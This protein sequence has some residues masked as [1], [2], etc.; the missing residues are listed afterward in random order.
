MLDM[1]VYSFLNLELEE[2]DSDAEKCF[3]YV[4]EERVGVVSGMCVDSS[5]AQRTRKCL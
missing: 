4:M 3:I 5:R 1:A 2:L